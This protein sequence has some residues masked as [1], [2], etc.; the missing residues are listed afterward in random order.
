MNE[1]IE[2]RL[3]RKGKLQRIR[4]QVPRGV[5]LEEADPIG[6]TVYIEFE[7]ADPISRFRMQRVRQIQDWAPSVFKLQVTVEDGSLILRGVDRHSLPEGRY[8]VRVRIEQA[9]TKAARRS[10]AVPHDGFGVLDVD[11][12]LDERDVDVNLDDGDA[13]ILRVLAASSVDGM[14]AAEWLLDPSFRP[15]RKACLLNLLASLRVRPTLSDHLLARV[16][17]FYFVADDRAFARV[18]HSVHDALE[19]LA[20]DPKKPFYREGRPRAPIHLKLLEDLP[21]P[22]ETSSLFTRDS[23]VSFRGEGRPTLQVVVAKTPP[24]LRHSYAEFDLDLGNPLQD[25]VGIVVH[26]GELLDGKPTN[27]LDM[28]K[29]LAKGRTRDFLHYTVVT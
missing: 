16:H 25:L 27:H 3:H 17:E 2:V 19:A 22:P 21:E 1:Y 7:A 14:V 24:G 6:R 28:R 12:T 15:T 13:D 9:T 10:V 4:R 23:L 29:A 20:V 11:I 8:N 5:E 18:D 26:L